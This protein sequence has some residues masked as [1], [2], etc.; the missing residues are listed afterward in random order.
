[1]SPV[2]VTSQQ[3]HFYCNNDKGEAVINVSPTI[4]RKRMHR[5]SSSVDSTPVVNVPSCEIRVS[6]IESQQNSDAGEGA[7]EMCGYCASSYREWDKM[8]SILKRPSNREIGE[9]VNGKEVVPSLKSL[10]HLHLPPR[11][12]CDSAFSSLVSSPNISSQERELSSDIGYRCSFG[13]D[14]GVSTAT[15]DTPYYNS[16]SN[17]TLAD[18]AVEAENGLHLS[19]QYNLS[20]T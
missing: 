20:S 6:S 15:L 7:R 19:F 16:D 10:M 14:S 9:S 4:K 5:A 12:D 11:R 17:E 3:Q 8:E 13:S 1:M 18:D 2:D